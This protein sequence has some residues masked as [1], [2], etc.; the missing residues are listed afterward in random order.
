MIV[1][2]EIDDFRHAFK[3][4]QGIDLNYVDGLP[5]GRP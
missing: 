4:T 3:F 5:R 1:S 2:K